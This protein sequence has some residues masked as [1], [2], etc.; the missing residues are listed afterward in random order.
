V[1]VCGRAKYTDDM[2]VPPHTLHAALVPSPVPHGKLLGIDSSAAEAL[3]GVHGVFSAKDVP[4]KNETGA[5]FMDE[6]VFAVD[7]LTCVGQVVAVVVAESAALA[8][9]A[10]R[11]IKVRY[12]LQQI[13]FLP[14]TI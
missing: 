3:P 10:C 1:Q 13:S 9:R 2:D 11:L 12:L 4:G 8:L 6:H 7:E 5:T 14:L